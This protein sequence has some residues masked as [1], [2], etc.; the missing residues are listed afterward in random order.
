[1]SSAGASTAEVRAVLTGSVTT[2][3]ASTV[4]SSRKQ[5]NPGEE[6]VLDLRP[7]WRFFLR[8]VLCLLL[9]LVGFVA[10][11]VADLPEWGQLGLAG[12]TLAA[13]CWFAGRYARWATTSFVVTT[14]RLIHRSGVFAK[15]ATEIRLENVQTVFLRQSFV[16]RLLRSGDLV[17]ESGGEHGRQSF[18]DIARP[19][20]VQ[21]EINRQIEAN[22]HRM[23]GSRGG[24]SSIPEQIQQ[25]DDLRR[26]GVVTQAEFDA[27]KA[28][29]LDRL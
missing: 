4:A 9:A 27:K 1:V 20:L 28:T 12:I 13:L 26:R 19:S 5:L 17:I 7:H 22:G 15:R 2:S 10:G 24:G 6:V 11:A 29:L 8:P 21:D 14:D 23:S 3:Y 16:E 18:S 25:L